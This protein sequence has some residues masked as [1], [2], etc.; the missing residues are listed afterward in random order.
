MFNGVIK[1][2]WSIEKQN[3]KPIWDSKKKFYEYVSIIHKY[4][5]EVK[6]LLSIA[7]KY[8]FSSDTK[9]D[10]SIITIQLNINYIRSCDYYIFNI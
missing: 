10:N 3:S 5:D 7:L 8:K 2:S 9:G 4:W 6:W 1:N